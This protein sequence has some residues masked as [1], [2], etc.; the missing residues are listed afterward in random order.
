MDWHLFIGLA[1]LVLVIFTII[2]GTGLWTRREK[3]KFLVTKPNYN[4]N[5]Y[6]RVLR[7]FWSVEIQ[8]FGGQEV[9]Y[10][11]QICLKPDGQ[12]YDKLKRYFSL[13]DDGVIR[14]NKRLAL[15]RGH[16]ASSGHG[17]EAAYPEYG[18]LMKTNDIE[19]WKIARQLLSE[20]SQKAFKVCLVWE[21]GGKTKWKTIKQQ[22]HGWITL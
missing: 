16:I 11:A 9:H 15:S 10:V 17:D 21:D 12:T 7:V 8:K 22:D 14:I 19:K 4:A 1:T 18:T 13:P 20:L 6:D 2:W 3:V 5:E